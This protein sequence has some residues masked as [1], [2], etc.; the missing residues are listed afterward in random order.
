MRSILTLARCRPRSRLRRLAP[1][2]AATEAQAARA[3]AKRRSRSASNRSR[4]LPPVYQTPNAC[5]S[6]EGY[7][8]FSSCDERRLL[9][10]LHNARDVQRGR[11][12]G[13]PF[14]IAAQRQ[15]RLCAHIHVARLQHIN[16]NL[17]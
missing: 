17:N 10:A 7:G 15:V 5:W 12:G 9:I 13:P 3:D 8:R 16:M 4:W 6:D 2:S 14:C 1:A 11:A